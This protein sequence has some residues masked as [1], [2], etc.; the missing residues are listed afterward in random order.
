LLGSSLHNFY[1]AP[2]FIVDLPKPICGK[3]R[4]IGEAFVCAWHLFV[5]NVRYE[6]LIKKTLIAIANC[7]S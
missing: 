4:R 5:P 7:I 1:E 2:Q 3:L 6:R